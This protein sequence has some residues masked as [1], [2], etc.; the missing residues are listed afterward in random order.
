MSFA[1]GPLRPEFRFP[2]VI[3]SGVLLNMEVGI[4]KRAWH[5]RIRYTLLIYDH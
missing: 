4:R 5:T 1:H 2:R 3:F